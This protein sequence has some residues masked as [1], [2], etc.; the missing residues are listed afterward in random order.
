MA[1]YVNC[2]SY[3][4]RHGSVRGLQTDAAAN[5]GEVWRAIGCAR[6]P[7]CYRGR[8]AARKTHHRRVSQQQMRMPQVGDGFNSNRSEPL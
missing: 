3:D 7:H 1:V 5:N 2:K 4:Q 6:R 8:V